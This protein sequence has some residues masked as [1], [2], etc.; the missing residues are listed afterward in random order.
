MC[1]TDRWDWRWHGGTLASG[2]NHSVQCFDTRCMD[3]SNPL[4]PWNPPASAT[5]YFLGYGQ[6]GFGGGEGHQMQTYASALELEGVLPQRGSLQPQVQRNVEDW[7]QTLWGEED[8][9]GGDRHDRQ[10]H[11]SHQ[12][13]LSFLGHCAPPSLFLYFSMFVAFYFSLTRAAVPWTLWTVLW[14]CYYADVYIQLFM[15]KFT[16]SFS[17]GRWFINFLL[18]EG[19]VQFPGSQ[20]CLGRPFSWGEFSFF[21]AESSGT[22]SVIS[23]YFK[24]KMWSQ[25]SRFTTGTAREAASSWIELLCLNIK[26]DPPY[27]WLASLSSK[28]IVQ[29]ISASFHTCYC[30]SQFRVMGA[31]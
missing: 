23:L 19:E 15:Q 4:Y 31:T 9:P 5:V 13:T 8:V 6:W 21:I 3:E 27:R 25:K 22:T 11:R 12:V 28:Y 30:Q 7:R 26:N 17:P 29:H 16:S 24:L 14:M 1:E 18:G 20:S 2:W 10:F